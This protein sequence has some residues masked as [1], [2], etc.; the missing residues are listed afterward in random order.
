MLYAKVL[1]VNQVIEKRVPHRG[2]P[3]FAPICHFFDLSTYRCTPSG[4]RKCH[5][6]PFS[7]AFRRL[8]VE[9]WN[10]KNKPSPPPPSKGRWIFCLQKIRRDC[11][12][13]GRFRGVAPTILP[14]Q[15]V[16][17]ILRMPQPLCLTASPLTGEFPQGGGRS[18]RTIL[19]RL[20][21]TNH[22]RAKLGGII[23]T[24]G[25]AAARSPRG[26]NSPPDCYSLP[27]GRFTTSAV[28][29]FE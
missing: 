17:L 19:V 2:V 8:I 26:S 9:K 22:S 24:G 15:A 25:L 12:V 7:Y 14:P 27:L 18:F 23:G 13:G 1:F 4:G 5:S 16:P 3:F 11:F 20:P 28:R 29:C 6:A 10:W 21:P